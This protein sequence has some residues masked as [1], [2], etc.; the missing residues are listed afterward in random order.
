LNFV[1]P[2]RFPQPR[3]AARVALLSV[4]LLAACHA[5]GGFVAPSSPEAAVRSFLNAVKANSI[6][7]MGE[8]W[9]SK[10]GPASRWMERT[11]MEQSLTVIRIYLDHDKYEIMPPNGASLDA[12]ERHR[13]DVRIYRHNGCTPVVP[14]TAIRAGEGWLVVDIDLAAAG[15]PAIPCKSGAPAPGH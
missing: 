10:D 11:K 1:V 13:V 3:S 12:P 5:G 15:N 2:M 4:S 14:L 9:G 6:A 8:L 7:G